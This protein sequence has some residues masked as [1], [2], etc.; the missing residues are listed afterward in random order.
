MRAVLD[1]LRG[2]LG[3]T[4][5]TT[6]IGFLSFSLSPIPPVRAFGIFMAV[7]IITCL[8]WSLTVIPALLVLLPRRGLPAVRAAG[9]SPAGSRFFSRLSAVIDR[10][11]R[12]ILWGA[13]ALA[14]LTPFGIAR[15]E[16]QDSWIGGFSP[17]SAFSRATRF[18]NER[19]SGAHLLL[20][21]V[22][23]GSLRLGGEIA[24]RDVEHHEL[25][26]P[27][28]LIPDPSRL[29]GA[30]ITIERPEESRARREAE[31]PRGRHRWSSW[32]EAAA[33]EGGV[34]VA[35]LPEKEGSPRFFLQ[36]AGE[37]LLHYEIHSQGL[38]APE[39]LRRLDALQ[40]RI[41]REERHAVGGVL[42]PTDYLKTTHFIVRKREGGSRRLPE[43]PKRAQWLWGQLER[44]RG[45]ERVRQGIDEEYGQGI[46]TVFLKNA[47]FA[48]TARLIETIRSHEREHLEPH[49]MRVDLAGDVAVSQTLIA[50]IVHTQVRSLLLSLAGIVLVA[51]LLGRAL[52]WGL[53]SV[54]PCALAL[55]ANF[56]VMG[57]LGIP[58]GVATSMFAGMILG[59]GVDYAI[60]LL[61][62]F[63]AAA[64]AGSSPEEACGE[65]LA[66]AGPA[67][68][69]DGLAVACGFG[70]LIL[71]QVPANAHLGALAVVCIASC[72]A[73]SLL[74][75]P[76]LLMGR[77][78]GGGGGCP[79]VPATST[80]ID[81]EEDR[82]DH[83]RDERADRGSRS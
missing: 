10:R 17:E 1:E 45:R 48:D 34:I 57:W 66:V 37:E 4:S 28:A 53:L 74:L 82:H 9:R 77:R 56:A 11:R 51:G 70:V 33:L 40:E 15:L 63:R 39:S 75:A 42:G 60:H 26:L 24:G 67:I 35:T 52:R 36:P 2:A 81:R 61:E 79:C 16:V 38:L 47:N 22:D 6:A 12:A 20:L 41:E 32:I 43:N 18:Y 72:L 49:G 13:I 65:A 62:R 76:A 55:A 7:G 54:L 59:I 14:A 30:W 29:A 23:A 71:S 25:R 21:R 5:I 46:V 19:F 64:A 69:I 68:L 50:S 31:N 80:L 44:I 27:I 78:P 8:L 73:G 58:L 83:S 3:K